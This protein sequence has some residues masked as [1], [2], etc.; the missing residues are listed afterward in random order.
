MMRDRLVE[1][2]KTRIDN[3][4]WCVSE[5]A[6]YL[7]ANGVIVPPCKVGDKIFFVHDMCD[8]NGEEYVEIS[9][10]WCVSFSLD[11]LWMY[12]RYDGD[13]TMWHCITNDLGQTVFLTKEDA[14]RALK[15]DAEG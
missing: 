11:G 12:C 4:T 3:K 2:I 14:E 7:I 8:E 9:N 10:G 6:D 1:L 13:L 15:G 5:L